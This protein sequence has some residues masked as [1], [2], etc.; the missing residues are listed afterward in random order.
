MVNENVGKRF[1]ADDEQRRPPR[2]P[3]RPY[4]ISA[5]LGSIYLVQP[6]PNETGR[7]RSGTYIPLRYYF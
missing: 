2:K 4:G 5:S 7:K 1:R 3:V 6:R